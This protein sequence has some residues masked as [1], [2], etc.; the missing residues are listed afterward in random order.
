MFDIQVL[1]KA[2]TKIELSNGD[3]QKYEAR[4]GVL[5]H[6]LHHLQG[7]DL[8]P[9]QSMSVLHRVHSSLLCSPLKNQRKWG[10]SHVR[11]SARQPTNLRLPRCHQK[12][13]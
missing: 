11:R 6:M 4:M 2:N 1:R 10:V 8:A 5:F 9:A 7:D 3:K 12:E 13:L